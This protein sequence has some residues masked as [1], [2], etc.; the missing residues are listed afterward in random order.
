MLPG[1]ESVFLTNFYAATSIFKASYKGLSDFAVIWVS[2]NCHCTVWTNFPVRQSL[3]TKYKSRLPRMEIATWLLC[4]GSLIPQIFLAYQ[5][6]S[7]LLKLLHT[8][9]ASSVQMLCS[10]PLSVNGCCGKQCSQGQIW[11]EGTFFLLQTNPH[12]LQVSTH[13]VA[14]RHEYGRFNHLS[15]AGLIYMFNGHSQWDRENICWLKLA[16]C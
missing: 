8:V 13:L 16:S 1:V 4:G 7:A 10:V 9:S 11:A 3:H 12:R 6:N 5:L 15:P 14:F 2:G